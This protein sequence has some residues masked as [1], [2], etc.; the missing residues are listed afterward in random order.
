MHQIT[1]WPDQ[2]HVWTQRTEHLVRSWSEQVHIHKR[3]CGSADGVHRAEHESCGG[4][5]FRICT[6]SITSHVLGS[7][8][9]RPNHGSE[10]P[11]D[12]MI[13]LTWS[14]PYGWS[15]YLPSCLL[16]VSDQLDC[17]SSSLIMEMP[18]SLHQLLLLLVMKLI[19]SFPRCWLSQ[20]H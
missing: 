3:M 8:S 15:R 5:L 20:C 9:P 6:C 10:G 13:A 2:F 17:S 18:A 11:V 12:V 14:A 7:I 4:S 1:E 19:I 16:Y